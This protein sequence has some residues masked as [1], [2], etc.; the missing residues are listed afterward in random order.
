MSTDLSISPTGTESISSK[1]YRWSLNVRPPFINTGSQLSFLSENYDEIHVKIKRNWRSQNYDGEI[2]GGTQYSVIHPLYNLMLSRNLPKD[3][4]IFDEG[5]TIEFD[6]SPDSDLY[7]KLEITHDEF[8]R[9]QD[10]LQQ[11][12]SVIRIYEAKLKNVD[13]EVC[14]RIERTFEIKR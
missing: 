14:T 4:S 9:I 7:A 10:E 1:L 2:S 8:Q 13:D 11:K 12:E 6:R 3:F 5:S